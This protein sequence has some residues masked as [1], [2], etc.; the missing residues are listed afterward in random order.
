MRTTTVVSAVR[1]ALS[2]PGAPGAGDRVVC[3]LS[4]GPD[5]VALLD[6]LVGVARE[7]ELKVV[8]AHLDHGLRPG[9]ADDARFCAELCASL[10]VPLRSGVADVAARAAR[11]GEGLESAARR[12]RYAFLRAVKRAEG[13]LA[14]AVAH[15][16]DDQAETV[17]LRLLRGSGR[18]GLAGMRARGRDLLRPLLN[19]SREE[20]LAHLRTRGLSWREDPTNADTALRRNRVRHELLPYLENRFN[21]RLK[22]A[23]ARTAAV[24]RDEGRLLAS[25][26]REAGLEAEAVNGGMALSRARLTGA[27]RAL[28]RRAV[29]E[30]LR[31]TGGLRDVGQG[32]VDRVLELAAA[33]GSGRALHLPARREAR[34]EFDALWLGPRRPAAAAYTLDL[35][36]PGRVDLPGGGALKAALDPGPA[37]GDGRAAVVAAPAQGLVV[38][39]RRPGDRVRSGRRRKSLKRFLM[40]RRVPASR[41]AELPLVAAGSEVLWVP[42]QRPP[43]VESEQGGAFVRLSLE[44]AEPDDGRIRDAR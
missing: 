13:A 6:A 40:E 26:A 35:P 43:R 20:V 44:E 38:R 12:E 14:I 15:T 8:A 32:H 16:Q 9:S 25:L 18:S 22:R 23:L 11:D 21:P 36:V 28:A 17:L 4:G 2:A 10:G 1:R 5:S 29:R 33:S 7:R 31:R 42:G 27:P 37:G 24:L 30:A 34:T 3:A 41:R 39:T 19:V